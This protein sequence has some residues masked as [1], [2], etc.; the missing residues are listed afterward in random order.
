MSPSSEKFLSIRAL[1][2]R[3][4]A[5]LKSNFLWRSAYVSSFSRLQL[6]KYADTVVFQIWVVEVAIA[7]PSF[8]ELALKPENDKKSMAKLRKKLLLLLNASSFKAIFYHIRDIIDFNTTMSK[9]KY[10][11]GKF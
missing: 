3:R 2:Q 1:I 9:P 8:V 5:S 6:T 7:N 10:A 11:H 4:F